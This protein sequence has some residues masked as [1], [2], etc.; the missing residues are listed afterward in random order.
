MAERTG[1]RAGVIHISALAT[2]TRPSH[3]ARHGNAYTTADQ[4]QWWDT[5]ANRINCKCTTISILIDRNGKVIQAETQ[6]EIK[7]EKT[8]FD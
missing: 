6:Q 2:T 1:L 4:N 7:A 8:F 3:A 5:G